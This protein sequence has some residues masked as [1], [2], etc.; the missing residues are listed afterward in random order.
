MQH[1]MLNICF[2][3]WYYHL[4]G[5]DKTDDV[6]EGLLSILERDLL[7][8]VL[9]LI[10]FKTLVLLNYVLCDIFFFFFK[11]TKNYCDYVSVFLVHVN[12]C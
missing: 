3:C 6:L 8:Q 2:I 1:R 10:V 5:N 11:F 9:L 4:N 7:A 12:V